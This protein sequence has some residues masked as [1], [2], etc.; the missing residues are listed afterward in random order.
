MVADCRYN[1]HIDG[2]HR[3]PAEPPRPAPPRARQRPT[4]GGTGA[5]RRRA[6]RRG[7]AAIAGPASRSWRL[8]D[9]AAADGETSLAREAERAARGWSRCPT[10]C[11]TPS[12]RS[13]S[14]PASS[15]S[16]QCRPASLAACLERAAR[17]AARARR[18][19]GRRQCRR[20][21]P[22]GGRLRRH[23]R[24]LQ[25]GHGQSVRLEGPA[26]RDGQHVPDAVRRAPSLP[27]SSARCAA[28][29]V[30]ILA[31]VPRGGTPLG[32][33]T[34]A[35]PVAVLLG[36]RGPGA[37]GGGRRAAPTRRLT[38]P[39]RPP[40]ESLNVADRRGADPL[41]GL[42]AAGAPLMSLFDDPETRR[43]RPRRAARRSPSA[44]G[45]ARSTSSSGRTS[46]SAP[47]P[48]AARGDRARPPAVDDPL[49]PAGHR[50]DDAGAAHRRR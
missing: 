33:A 47:G 25:R 3:E 41:R 9:G 37:A 7:G 30:T 23:R 17:A 22:R 50:Q 19:A 2:A 21:R 26:R 42:A 16:A 43:P 13:A 44:C 18:R 49:G 46:C 6:P 1:L 15:P 48:A 4:S 28:A 12:A 39:M 34:C 31:T 40:V 32:S 8:R 45:R 14:R 5:A 20:H 35:G 10:R 27:T 36:A 29:G 24:H 38:I 11:S